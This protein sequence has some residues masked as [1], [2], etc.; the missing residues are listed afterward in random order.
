MLS[1]YDFDRQVAREQIENLVEYI[2]VALKEDDDSSVAQACYHETRKQLEG[3]M[4]A[5]KNTRNYSKVTWQNENP[6]SSIDGRLESV[7][8][9][10]LYPGNRE[11]LEKQGKAALALYQQFRA[12]KAE[13]LSGVDLLK[14]IGEF[15]DDKTQ[16]QHSSAFFSTSHIASLPYLQRLTLLSASDRAIHTALALSW[17]SYTR[18]VQTIHLPEAQEKTENLI[19]SPVYERIPHNKKS[20]PITHS[21]DGGLLY[22]ERLMESAISQDK[23]LLATRALQSFFDTVNTFTNGENLTPTPYYAII[24]ADGDGMGK[25]IDYESRQ[26]PEQHQKISKALDRFDERVKTLVEGDDYSQGGL[27]YSGGDDVLAFVPLHNVLPCV[28]GLSTAFKDCLNDFKDKDGKKPT[29]S[30]GV[31]IV[32]HLSLLSEALEQA[33]SAERV[34]KAVS[35]KNALAIK[36]CRRSGEEYTISGHWG[37]LDV[38]LEKLIVHYQAKRIPAG[39]PY[40]LRESLLR[41]T[42]FKDEEYAEKLIMAIKADAKRILERKLKVPKR[43]KD[44]ETASL[45]RLL[46]NRV[47]LDLDEQAIPEQDEAQKPVANEGGLL[48][49]GLENKLNV[50]ISTFYRVMQI[51]V[52]ELIIAKELADALTLAGGQPTIQVQEAQV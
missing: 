1:K 51:Y 42:A 34:A 38:Y 32:H 49:D 13:R 12:G 10:S 7:L 33:R 18:E 22:G 29:L 27:V 19:L 24:V 50:K 52:H 15:G 6:K 9:R 23:L 2:W 8:P 30:V 36:L 37:N 17:N 47:A 44:S 21:R 35:G 4:A 28:K 3:L 48:I 31:A 40:D 11:S 46:A 39:L 25:L 45:L 16:Q 14:R 26:G 5:R 43:K 20:H 41:L